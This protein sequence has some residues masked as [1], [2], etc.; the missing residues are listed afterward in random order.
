MCRPF[1]FGGKISIWKFRSSRILWGVLR[2]AVQ[3]KMKFETQ[4]KQAL[5]FRREATEKE[6]RKSMILSRR[7]SE[8]FT[9]INASRSFMCKRKTLLLLLRYMF[10]M[11]SGRLDMQITYNAKTDVLYI[12]L[13]D[14]RQDVINRRISDDV[15]LDMGQNETIVG[16]EIVDASSHT[17]LKNILPIEYQVAAG[18]NG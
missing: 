17:N 11:E 9:N 12:R 4:S 3:A 15:V 13:D 14:R 1:C 18:V 6:K 2:N 10:F 5:I 16:I 7:G 8:N